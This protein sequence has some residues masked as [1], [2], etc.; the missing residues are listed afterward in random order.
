MLKRCLF[1]LIVLAATAIPAQ[2]SDLVSEFEGQPVGGKE[3]IEQTLQTQ[4][5]LPKIL[6]TSNFNEHVTAFFDLDS[7]G[8]A[9]NIS[10]RDGLNNA[11]RKETIRLF[12]FL[13]FKRTQSAAYEPYPYHLSYHI[14]TDRYNKFFKQKNKLYFKKPFPADS[15]YIIYT[16]AEKAPEYYKNG[17]EGLAE[18]ILSEIV[19]PDLAIEKSIEGTVI[20][21][22]VVET[23]GYVTGIL[24]RQGVNAGCTEEAIRL[25]KLTKWQPAILNN[26]FVRYRTTYPITFSLRNTSNNSSAQTIGQ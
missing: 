8:N 3:Q 2:N 13:K 25:I 19:Y 14:S 18:F 23:N 10:F 6:L 7:A 11:L 9:I 16:K 26:K 5:T 24:V 4:L 15:S 22:F 12:H 21:E 17:E 20:L 1:I